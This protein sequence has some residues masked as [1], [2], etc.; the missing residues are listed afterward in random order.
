MLQNFTL[1]NILNFVDLMGM[2]CP[3]HSELSV[4]SR[5][6]YRTKHTTYMCTGPAHCAMLLFLFTPA[7]V[8][9]IQQQILLFLYKTL[10]LFSYFNLLIFCYFTFISARY[11]V[12]Y[13][14]G[15]N[16]FYIYS[17]ETQSKTANIDKL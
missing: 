1:R 7:S 2:G 13:T 17:F 4:N 9:Q 12:I 16:D 11:Y 10:L 3:H 5:S 14:G 6:R 15:H 8:I